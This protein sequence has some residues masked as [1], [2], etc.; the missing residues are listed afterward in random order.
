MKIGM[1][2]CCVIMFLPILGFFMLGGK[3]SGFGN[4]LALFAPL[5]LCVGAHL[6]MH[7]LLGKSCHGEKNEN[8]LQPIK[9]KND[10]HSKMHN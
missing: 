3:V 4:S 1:M 7:R 2:A 10:S 5:I 8:E 6:I 9:V